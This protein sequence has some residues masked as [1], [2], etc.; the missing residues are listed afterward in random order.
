MPHLNPTLPSYR[1]HKASGQSI[2]T[3]GGRDFYLGPHG[4]PASRAKYQRLIREYV[5]AG[6]RMPTEGEDQDLTVAQLVKRYQ[7]FAEREYKNP[8]GTPTGTVYNTI[9]ALRALF[10]HAADVPVTAFGP[11]LLIQVRETLVEA[12]LARVTINA[13]IGIIKRAFK[14]AAENELIPAS[15]FHG[16]STVRGLRRGRGGARET[17]R[18]RPV[19]EDHVQKAIPFMPEPVQAM[20]KLQ[21]MTAARPGEIVTMR[22]CDID[23]TGKTWLYRPVLHKNSWLEAEREIPLGPQAREIVSKWMRPGLQE[24]YLFSPRES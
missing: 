9:L 5:N 4:T 23:R 12:G 14:W 10:E 1:L 21:L 19:P 11:K 6:F 20:V 24:Q 3:L 22:A 16:L 15:V 7:A 17:E 2:V 8:D 18:I 13:R